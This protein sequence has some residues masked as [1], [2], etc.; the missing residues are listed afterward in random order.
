MPIVVGEFDLYYYNW[1]I[2][3]SDD[4]L[5]IGFE[6][7]YSDDFICFNTFEKFSYQIYKHISRKNRNII[8][9]NKKTY[10]KLKKYEVHLRRGYKGGYVFGFLQSEFDELYNI[11]KNL[12]FK[13]P[14]KYTCNSCNLQLLKTLGKLYYEYDEKMKEK[15]SK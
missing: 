13:N 4:C 7:D 3:N 5:Y 2:Y 10:E 12:G 9:I 1:K 14:L 15:E 11:Y 6:L 8:M